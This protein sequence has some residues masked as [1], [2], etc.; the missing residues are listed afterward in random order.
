LSP[1][2]DTVYSAL[3][4]GASG[5]LAILVAAYG[6]KVILRAFKEPSREP[7]DAWERI[8][9]AENHWGPMHKSLERHHAKVNGSIRTGHQNGGLTISTRTERR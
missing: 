4:G 9:A 1:I 3:V 6:L 8:E 5:A 7:Q 2:S